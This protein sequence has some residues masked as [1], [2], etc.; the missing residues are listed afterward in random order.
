V[1]LR[2]C[3]RSNRLRRRVAR[4]VHPSLAPSVSDRRR[5]ARRDRTGTIVH[6]C[7]SRHLVAC[8]CWSAHAVPY[9]ERREKPTV[10][11]ADIGEPSTGRNDRVPRCTQDRQRQEAPHLAPTPSTFDLTFALCPLPYGPA[12][13]P[14]PAQMSLSRFESRMPASMRRRS[15]SATLLARY[16]CVTSTGLIPETQSPPIDGWCAIESVS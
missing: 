14:T 7:R 11:V 9:Q 12:L 2:G 16:P 3:C 1:L 13:H 5:R 6:R 8:G 10:S 4:R 15:T